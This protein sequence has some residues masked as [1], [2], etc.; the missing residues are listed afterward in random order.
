MTKSYV[1]AWPDEHTRL[2]L[3]E[4]GVE[5]EIHLTTFFDKGGEL[6][7]MAQAPWDGPQFATVTKVTLW[8]AGR[9]R[10]IVAEVEAPWAAEIHEH[11][12]AQSRDS[13]AVQSRRRH[14]IFHPH[15][16]LKRDAG[17][18]ELANFMHLVGMNLTFDR[19]GREA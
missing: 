17:W 11:Y 2:L 15:V 8:Y 14:P 4:L 9:S 16:T 10:H 1:A 12:A 5:K 18:N 7:G 13:W 6:E 3:K 19:H